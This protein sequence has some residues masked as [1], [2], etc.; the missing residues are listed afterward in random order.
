MK[1]DI[2]ITSMMMEVYTIDQLATIYKFN[3]DSFDGISKTALSEV[4]SRVLSIQGN[5]TDGSRSS[6][7]IALE[8]EINNYNESLLSGSED[9]GSSSNDLQ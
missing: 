8:S 2:R 3:H 7:I 1:I 4:A 5:T 9:H 6:I